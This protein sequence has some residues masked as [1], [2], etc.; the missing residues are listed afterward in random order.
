MIHVT[1][2]WLSR[3]LIIWEWQQL[4]Q[5]PVAADELW[6]ESVVMENHLLNEHSFPDYWRVNEKQIAHFAVKSNF[7][8]SNPLHSVKSI[9]LHL[10][11]LMI[12]IQEMEISLRLQSIFIAW[13]IRSEFNITIKWNWSSILKFTISFKCHSNPGK[14][15]SGAIEA[16][17][18]S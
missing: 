8:P 12:C 15:Y 11:E 10:E 16:I 17:R 18:G 5:F 3:K 14:Q 4:K 9:H 6:I 1:N 2:H 13:R 7:G